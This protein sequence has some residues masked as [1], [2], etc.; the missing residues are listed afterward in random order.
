MRKNILLLVM[1]LMG[2]ANGLKAETISI[3][4][5]TITQGETMEVAVKLTNTTTNLIAFSFT[6]TMPSGITIVDAKTT[7]RYDGSLTIGQPDS[8]IY[9]I[10]GFN[11]SENAISG[12]EGDFIILTVTA[13]DNFR[14]G[15]GVIEEA[16][17]ITD[18]RQHVLADD[19]SFVIDF[20]KGSNVLL[21]DANDDG[22]VNVTD[23]MTVVNYLLGRENRT[24]SEVNADVNEDGSIDVTD[25][26]K[27]VNILLGRS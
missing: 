20:I 17:F 7:D 16:D 19:S 26:M 27:I 2:F 22:S 15:T 5:F 14:G 4:D 8:N 23:V 10:C 11:T 21:G 13:A 18:D 6:V 24:F 12:S 3:D 25:I 1:A 9:K